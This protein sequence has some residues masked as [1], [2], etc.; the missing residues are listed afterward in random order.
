MRPL[1]QAVECSTASCLARL[2]HTAWVGEVLGT[3]PAPVICPWR[4]GIRW[5]LTPPKERGTRSGASP[6]RTHDFGP[7]TGSDPRSTSGKL[8][9]QVRILPQYLGVTR[10]ETQHFVFHSQNQGD[11]SRI[12]RVQSSQLLSSTASGCGR[13]SNCCLDAIYCGSR[14]GI[15]TIHGFQRSD[16]I[17]SRTLG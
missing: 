16:P 2:C 9:A 13:A 8:L 5:F 4:P 11:F 1:W 3:M 10:G 15:D 17:R 14:V 6:P 7:I 12:H